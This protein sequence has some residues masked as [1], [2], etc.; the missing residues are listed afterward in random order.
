MEGAG[1]SLTTEESFVQ[2]GD[3][4]NLIE[5]LNPQLERNYPAFERT[6]QAFEW[7][8]G[9]YYATQRNCSPRQVFEQEGHT[10]REQCTRIPTFCE[11]GDSVL[12]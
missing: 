2:G 9:S 1:D 7:Y 12:D 6:L 4:V 10:H 8:V 3:L 5:D 11:R